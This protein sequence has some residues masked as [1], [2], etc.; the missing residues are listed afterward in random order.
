[1]SPREPFP[2]QCTVTGSHHSAQSPLGDWYWK[3]RPSICLSLTQ[4]YQGLC[5]GSPGGPLGLKDD[6]LHGVSVLS[7]GET[8]SARPPTSMVIPALRVRPAMEEAARTTCATEVGGTRP[9]ALVWLLAS[10]PHLVMAEVEVK[11]DPDSPLQPSLP[12]STLCTQPLPPV[13]TAVLRCPSQAAPWPGPSGQW[14]W[15]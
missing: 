6:L 11:S 4:T 1:M 13:D 2:T 10:E 8:G 9:I 12:L 5:L 7:P 3:R 14:T 15:P